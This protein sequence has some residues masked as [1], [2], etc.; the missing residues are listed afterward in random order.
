MGKEKIKQIEDLAK[1]LEDL[2][3][4]GKRIVH[5]HGV[6]DLLHPGHVE[7][8]LAAKK[9]GDILVVTLTKDEFIQKGP[10]RPF[11]NQDLRVKFI[12]SLECVDYTALNKWDTAIETIKLL[13]PNIYVKGKEVLGNKNIDAKEDKLN[14]TKSNLDLEL[15]E[16]EKHNGKL[17]LTD[18]ATFSSSRII[19]QIT[20]EIS[21]ESKSYLQVLTKIHST[22]EIIKKIESL[23]AIKPLIIGDAILDEYIYCN[24]MDKSGK[25]G[26]IAHKYRDEEIHVGGAFAVANHLAGF[27][28]NL[29]LITCVGNNYPGLIESSLKDNINKKIIFQNSDQTLVKRRYVEKYQN[30]KIFEIYNVEGLHTNSQSEDLIIT[31][32]ENELPNHDLVLISDFGHGMMTPKIINYLVDSQKP[33]AINCQFNG[34]NM[35]YNFI[36]KYE[37]ANFVSLNDREVRVPFQEKLSDIAIPIKKLSLKLNLN[38]INIT[39]GKAGSTYYKNGGFYNCPSFT[40]NTKDTIGAGDSVF[41]LTSL[42][43]HKNIEPELIPFLGNSIGALTTQIIGNRRSVDSIELKKFIS[44][45]LK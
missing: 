22:E 21:E 4:Q 40:K 1:L 6:F 9:Q 42:L 18:E 5:C 28:D 25:E 13:K 35:G 27:V 37:R 32:L 17:Y 20:S 23:R 14:K 24:Q 33:L 3:S 41:A 44:Y 31:Y 34:G 2:K 10:G 29:T 38:Q 8:F 7:H 16:L 36:T 26:V 11:Y 45:I 30:R 39:R 12:S 15:E 19:N 43:S